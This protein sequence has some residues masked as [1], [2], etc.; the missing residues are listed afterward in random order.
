MKEEESLEKTYAVSVSGNAG[1]LVN[2]RFVHHD[3]P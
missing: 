1:C 2:L 3:A